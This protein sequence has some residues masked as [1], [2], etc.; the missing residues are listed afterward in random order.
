MGELSQ[1]FEK[2]ILSSHYYLVTGML[3]PLPV[4]INLCGSI[5]HCLFK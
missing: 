2:Q 5:I 3:L 4:M 1:S